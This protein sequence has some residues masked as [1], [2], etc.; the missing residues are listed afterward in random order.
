MKINGDTK[1]NR[2]QFLYALAGAMVTTVAGLATSQS[3]AAGTHHAAHHQHESPHE[4][5][6]A[7]AHQ[8]D[9][10][11]Q[12]SHFHHN[13]DGLDDHHHDCRHKGQ[14]VSGTGHHK[15][16]CEGHDGKWMSSY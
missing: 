2:R 4:H 12:D 3:F 8:H 10:E 5:H 7:R 16:E 6:A 9:G 14:V 15:E 1:M 11:T 13:H